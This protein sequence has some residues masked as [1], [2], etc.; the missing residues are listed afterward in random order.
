MR[1][2]SGAA[3][4]LAV[5]GVG[6]LGGAHLRDAPTSAPVP[7]ECWGCVRIG[8]GT[9][10]WGEFNCNGTCTG[11]TCTR[12]CVGSDPNTTPNDYEFC[13]CLDL[14][15]LPEEDECDEPSCCHL[16]AH[17]LIHSTEGTKWLNK[18]TGGSCLACPA[19]GS[20]KPKADASG[21]CS[22]S[23]SYMAVCE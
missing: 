6:L 9:P 3:I 5:L 23:D 7:L 21:Q 18:T 16:R 19:S 20:C 2:R 14:E 4:L 8:D 12:W 1:H 22:G 10:D 13:N 15:D 17:F 11:L